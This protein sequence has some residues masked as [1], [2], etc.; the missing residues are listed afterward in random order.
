MWRRLIRWTALLLILAGAAA[1]AGYL[2]LRVGRRFERNALCCEIPR[3]HNLRISL[4]EALGLLA[5]PSQ[6]GQDRWVG[7]KVFP[8]VRDGYFL[9]VGSAD[10]YTDSNTWALE[11]RGWTGICVDPFPKNM[12]GRTCQMFKDAVGRTAGEKVTFTQAGDIGGITE[13]LGRWKP[14]TKDAPT[15]ELTTVTLEDILRRANAPSYI[16]FVSIDIEGAELDALAG[17][18]FDRYSVGALAIEHNYEEPKRTAIEQF[19]H[20]RGYERARTWL[21]DDFYLPRGRQ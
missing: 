21:Q 6:I 1:A 18:P 2:G 17:F 12:E 9:D 8:G 13:T 7:E 5:F 4:R 10:G 3:E 11:R 19:L 20:E 15:V 14:Y 16:H